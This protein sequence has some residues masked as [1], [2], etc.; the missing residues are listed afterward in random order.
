MTRKGEK[1]VR[2]GEYDRLMINGTHY[3]I[4][5][6]QSDGYLLAREGSRGLNEFYSHVD[7]AAGLH[8]GKM[9]R[10]RGYFT[11]SATRLRHH[12]EVA[13]LADLSHSE[14]A[15]ILWK[16][17]W[18][19][20]YLK[21]KQTPGFRRASASQIVDQIAPDIEHMEVATKR[22]TPRKK[23]AGSAKITREPPSAETL[24][25]WVRTLE[26]HEY[27]PLAL[28]DGRH[29]RSGNFSARL[30]P[31][32]YALLASWA[33]NY[34]DESCPTVRTVYDGLIA[35]LELKNKEREARGKEA[36]APP[37]FELL[38]EYVRALPEFDKFAARKGLGAAERKYRMIGAGLGD[39]VVRPLQRVEMD[40]WEAHLQVRL[41]KA[42]AWDELPPKVK[43]YLQ[44]GR[45]VVTAAV[46]Y[47]TGCFLGL[48]IELTESVDAALNCLRMMTR[49]KTELARSLA[50]WTDWYMSGTAEMVVTDNG[51]AFIAVPFRDAIIDMGSTHEISV[52]GVP[53][54]RSTV[55]SVFRRFARD[56]VAYF[57]GRTFS[58]VVEKGEYPAEK[59]ASVTFDQ[60]I[61][62]W[63]RWVVDVYHNTP[64]ARLGGQTPK[65]R[66][67]SLIDLY[68]VEPGPDREKARAIFGVEVERVLGP[69]GV[70]FMGIPYN[71]VA[72]QKHRRAIGDIAVAVR[73]DLED[74]G[75]GSVKMGDEW[76]TVPTHEELDGVTL[77]E[78]MATCAELRRKM[79][80]A[81]ERNREIILATLRHIRGIAQDAVHRAGFLHTAPT[82]E[83]LD[84]AERNIAV[85]FDMGD[86]QPDEAG[87]EEVT[88]RLLAKLPPAVERPAPSAAPEQAISPEAPEPERPMPKRRK[89]RME[90][91]DNV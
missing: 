28:R 42:G 65:E 67:D 80:G 1:K 69:H 4:R 9:L 30:H 7:I 78:W 41:R 56:V 15:D 5:E 44:T 53:W 6:S 90:G 27:N 87:V 64:Q 76:V 62:V 25:D 11:A 49:D 55:E 17:E 21:L 46:D 24:L 83:E 60:F 58:T 14:Q 26:K 89:S 8:S 43:E 66:W 18:C 48:S 47:A 13:C 72:I 85:A 3:S 35:D 50:F 12:L 77:A 34:K 68:G 74:L 37:S 73:I 86:V 52:G 51:S 10:E 29:C 84:R 57:T 40:G 19:R 63:I 70:R 32:I 54:L 16:L 36:L 81:Q 75:R 2:L 82:P 22:G 38:G 31:Q 45:P 88:R 23:T 79:R 61:Q 59:R 91:E 20:R 33:E 39:T 71:S